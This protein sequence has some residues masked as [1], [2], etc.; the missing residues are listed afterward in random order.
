MARRAFTICLQLFIILLALQQTGAIEPRRLTTD[1]G[2][3]LTPVF[4]NAEELIY[5]DF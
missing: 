5:V 4:L 2:I 3:K 1:G